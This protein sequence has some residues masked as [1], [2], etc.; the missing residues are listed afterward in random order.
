MAV[1]RH[2]WFLLVG[3][4]VA[5]GGSLRDM[6]GAAAGGA[7]PA[8]IDSGLA[9]LN[10]P[11]TRAQI[12]ELVASPE[13]ERATQQLVA[14]LADG[15]LAAL[16]E[17]ERAGRISDAS[18][19][20]VLEMATSV[21]LAMRQSIG[22]EV[23]RMVSQSVD[24]SLQR[25][26]SDSNQARMQ[27]MIGAV[28]QESVSAL[29]ISMNTELRPM[30]RAMLREDVG[31]AL[32]DGLRDPQT[33]AALGATMR[34]FTRQAVLGMQDGFEEIDRRQEAGRGR[35]TLLTRMQ[36]LVPDSSNVMRYSV[37]GLGLAMVVL[38]VWL[39]RTRA[40]ASA[41]AAESERQQAALIAL[42]EAI[43]ATEDQPWNKDL[44]GALQR[45]LSDRDSPYQLEEFLAQAAQRKRATGEPRTKPPKSGPLNPRHA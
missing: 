21:G 28:V 30:L 9:T 8:V 6:A 17:E 11:E 1:Y 38:V 15:M 40:K 7:T 41:A 34:I 14:N 4:C 33:Q 45:T 44:V 19:A 36:M 13:V 2:F 39:L 22:P 29:A 5:C 27:D 32:R 3:A 37:V 43:K 35:D 25:A 42:T 12:A 31:A 20:F 26:L 16:T 10:D 24:A 18:K 23:V